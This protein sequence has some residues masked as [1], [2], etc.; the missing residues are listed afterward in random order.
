[1]GVDRDLDDLLA[2]PRAYLWAAF[3]G[4]IALGVFLLAV[5]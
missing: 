1:M 3:F 2:P 5:L 4:T